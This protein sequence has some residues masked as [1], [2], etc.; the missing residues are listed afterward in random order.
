MIAIPMLA[1]P[2]LASSLP[3]RRTRE[4]ACVGRCG[5]ARGST[6]L[7]TAFLRCCIPTLILVLAACGGAQKKPAE[8]RGALRFDVAPKEAI[9]EVDETR[10]GPASMLMKQGLLLKVGQH[11]VVVSL[12]DCFPEYRLV[13]VREGEVVTLKIELTPT[14]K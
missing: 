3:P 4:Y 12:E 7:G 13:D 2:R 11:R 8:P 10:L 9:V 1:D 6:N 14:P 5:G